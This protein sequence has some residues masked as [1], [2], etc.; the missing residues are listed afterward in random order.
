MWGKL[1]RWFP[2]ASSLGGYRRD[3]LRGDLTA[4]LTTAVMLVPQ[5]M[6][7]AMLAGL[8]PI[9]GLYASTVPLL[10]Y[11]LL[12]TSRHLAVGPVAMVSL[13]TAAAVGGLAE[14]GSERYVELAVV[15]ALMVGA[16]QIAMGLA[17]VGFLVNF[18]SH[19]VISGFT[20]AAALIIGLS[21]LNHLLGIVTPRSPYIHEILLGAVAAIG[22]V[23]PATVVIGGASIAALVL[24]RRLSPTIPGAL[25]VVVVSSLAV[26]GLGLHDRGVAIVGE[27]PAGLPGIAF[28]GLSIET[29][30]DL[31]PSALAISLV[32]FMESVSVAKAMASRHR[33]EID[34]NRELG[35]LGLANVVGGLFGGYPVTGGFSRTA[36]NSQAGARTAVASIVTAGFIGVTLLFFTPLFY[37]LPKAVLAAIVMTAVFG[38]IDVREVVHLFKVNRIDLALLTLTFVVTLVGGIEA[39]ILTGVVASLLAFAARTTRPHVAV[40]GRLPGRAVYRNVE[41]HPE[42]ETL[43]GIIVLRIDAQLYYGNA[44]FLDETVNELLDRSDEPVRAVVLDAS[45]VNGIDSSADRALRGLV[46]KLRDRGVGFFVGGVKGPV[47]DALRRSGLLDELVDRV[48]LDVHEAVVAAAGPPPAVAPAPALAGGQ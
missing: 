48:H 40:L 4:G 21:Q 10:A 31:L 3:D 16:I 46:G 18:L 32:A 45:A 30:G 17:R 1:A 39:G 13:M 43:P 9:V 7:Y 37:Y 6:A 22:D 8:P 5:S 47:A 35:G 28:P 2:I 33:Y 36:I 12:G 38:L 23:Q 41:R 26:L 44:A 29:L 14:P 15:L 24:L 11:A 42:A 25:A 34:A 20:S 19:P 27:V